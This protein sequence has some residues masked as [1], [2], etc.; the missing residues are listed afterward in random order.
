V[1]KNRYWKTRDDIGNSPETTLYIFFLTAFGP[2]Y[3]R[4]AGVDK[5]SCDVDSL[6]RGRVH[7]LQYS[8]IGNC[9]TFDMPNTDSTPVQGTSGSS[10]IQS[11]LM[12]SKLA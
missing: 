9:S 7:R 8:C 2:C 11:L 12:E 10:Q 4:F 5:A 3:D 6:W 1:K